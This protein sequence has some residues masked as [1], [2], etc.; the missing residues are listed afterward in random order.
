MHHRC[1]SLVVHFAAIVELKSIDYISVRFMGFQG[2]NYFSLGDTHDY[3]KHNYCGD[4][5]KIHTTIIQRH[6]LAPPARPRLQNASQGPCNSSSKM[7]SIFLFYTSIE[8]LYK[9]LYLIHLPI[10]QHN[11]SET[12]QL[13]TPN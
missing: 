9:I 5:L 10:N 4:L 2:Y 11:I 13:T 3:F 12:K 7:F 8:C 1:F 6:H